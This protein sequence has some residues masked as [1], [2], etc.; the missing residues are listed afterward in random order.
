MSSAPATLVELRE[1]HGDL[2]KAFLSIKD[3]L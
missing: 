3:G 2:A 1:R